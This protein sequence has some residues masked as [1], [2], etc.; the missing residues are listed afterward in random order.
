MKNVQSKLEIGAN[1]AIIVVAVLIVGLLIRLFFLPGGQQSTKTEYPPTPVTGTK[2]NLPGVDWE[3]QSQT[4]LMVLQKGCHYCSESAPFYQ[5]LVKSAAG[6]DVKFLAV[7]PQTKEVSENYLSELGI[8]GVET[9]QATLNSL[10]VRG[11]PTLI[12]VNEKGEITK[13]WIGRLPPEK[14]QEVFEH[15]KL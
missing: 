2:V 10:Q 12:V 7:I 14:E 5:K 9:K 8:S 1:I 13:V 4:V 3:H 11:T 15:L 6:K